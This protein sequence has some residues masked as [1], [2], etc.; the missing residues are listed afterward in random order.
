M[1]ARSS[2]DSMPYVVAAMNAIRVAMASWSPT[3]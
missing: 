3:R 1:L 2:I